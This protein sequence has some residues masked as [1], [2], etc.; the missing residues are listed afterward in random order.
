MYT[1]EE[2]NFL[3][4]VDIFEKTVGIQK[5]RVNFCPYLSVKIAIITNLIKNYLRYIDIIE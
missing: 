4:H 1:E 2:H 5:D 3:L